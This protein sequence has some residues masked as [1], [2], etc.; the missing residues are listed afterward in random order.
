MNN[1]KCIYVPTSSPEDWRK[2]LAEPDK[3]WRT[4]YSARSLAYCWEEANGLPTD[5]TA[6]LSQ[7][8]EFN[9]LK[10]LMV[11][12]EHQVPLPGGARPSQNDCWVLARTPIDLVSIAV[13]KR[14]GGRS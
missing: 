14:I 12:P 1:K 6:V 7:V 2:L 9:E 5:V 13:E 10:A 4:G 11:I 8:L 3:H